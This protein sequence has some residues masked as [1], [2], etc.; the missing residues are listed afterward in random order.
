MT[1][2]SCL[3]ESTFLSSEEYSLTSSW[4]RITAAQLLPV[5]AT[6][7]ASGT[8]AK[9]ASVLQNPQFAAATLITSYVMWGMATPFAMVILV[10]YYSRLAIHKLPSREVIVS[11]FLPLG[12]LGMGGFTIMF[13]GK[14]ARDVLPQVGILSHISSAGDI[15]Y[16]M[17]LLVAMV[18]WGFGIVWLVFALATIYSCRPFPFNMGWWGFTFPLGVFA[19]ST[20]N[21]GVEMPSMFFSVLGT[22]FAVMVMLLW[23]VVA[24]GTAKGASTGKLFHAP[25]LKNLEKPN[26]TEETARDTEKRV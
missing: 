3:R 4:D 26:Q 7:V 12:P 8:G 11:C 24:V 23:G 16:I 19:V 25:C 10:I 5:A 13:L 20:I 15:I 14:V 2:T 21:I 1:S 18:M 17:G 6:I 22:I 9:V